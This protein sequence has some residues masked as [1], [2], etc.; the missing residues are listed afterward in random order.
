MILFISDS[1]LRVIFSMGDLNLKNICLAE[2]QR[3]GAERGRSASTIMFAFLRLLISGDEVVM[4][5]VEFPHQKTKLRLKGTVSGS[6]SR[7]RR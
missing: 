4:K 2:S 6:R 5:K 1:I 3:L 7:L